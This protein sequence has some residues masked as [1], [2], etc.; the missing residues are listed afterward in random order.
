MKI[1]KL[2]TALAGLMLAPST[3]RADVI[4]GRW[5]IVDSL[6][7]GTPIVIKLKA[8]DRIE[9]SLKAVRPDSLEL[10]ESTGRET[11][12][13]KSDVK[14]IVSLVKKGDS[15]RNGVLWGLV[16]GGAGGTAAGAATSKRA[17]NEGGSG[18]GW[19]AIWGSVGAGIG[20]LAGFL[21]D[22]ARRSRPVFYRAP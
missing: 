15:L 1:P 11:T 22:A 6:E 3:L 5:E 21:G 4:P 8:G 17:T 9:C 12:I 2:I 7:P 19:A 13:L 10:V 18:V 20:A 14:E 16:I